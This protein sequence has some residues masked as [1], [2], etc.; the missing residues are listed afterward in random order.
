[1]E[2]GAFKAAK[3]EEARGKNGSI[4][5][6]RQADGRCWE[7]TIHS[8]G[9]QEQEPEHEAAETLSPNTT[10]VGAIF[11]ALLLDKRFASVTLGMLWAHSLMSRKRGTCA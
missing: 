11:E 7:V 2:L 9:C 10:L 6:G 1:M 4:Q 8:R 5:V 3:R